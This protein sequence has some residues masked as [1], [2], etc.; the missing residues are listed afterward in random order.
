[1]SKPSR[2]P[3]QHCKTE[4]ILREDFTFYKRIPRDAAQ[5]KQTHTLHLCEACAKRF[6]KMKKMCAV[7]DHTGLLVSDL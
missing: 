4:E 2:K 3:C 5:S 1:M 6:A 7:G